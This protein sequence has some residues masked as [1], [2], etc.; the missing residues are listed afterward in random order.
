MAGAYWFSNFLKRHT[1]LSLW[2]P[3]STNVARMTGSNKENPK[4]IYDRFSEVTD[5]LIEEGGEQVLSSWVPAPSGIQSTS[6]H[7]GGT[8]PEPISAIFSLEDVRP[9]PKAEPRKVSNCGKNRKGKQL[10]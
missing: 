7:A 5:R 3:E 9:F 6:S 10:P 8:R 4:Q 2:Q 1:G